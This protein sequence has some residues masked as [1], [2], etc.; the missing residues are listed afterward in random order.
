MPTPYWWLIRLCLKC[1]PSLTHTHTHSQNV[2]H[3][4]TRV[5]PVVFEPPNLVLRCLLLL[6]ARCVVFCGPS[7]VVQS[8]FPLVGP[9]CSFAALQTE[10]TAQGFATKH[11]V[12]SRE[13]CCATLE[14]S[15][16]VLVPGHVPA[17]TLC[18]HHP[19]DVS[20]CVCPCTACVDAAQLPVPAPPRPPSYSN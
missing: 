8:L 14:F 10:Q 5:L 11:K 17:S 7:P 19:C 9:T 12:L 13:P 15:C 4:L 1:A 20:C 3:L 2:L 6:S 18:F 16:H